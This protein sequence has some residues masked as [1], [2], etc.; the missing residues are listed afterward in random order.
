MNAEDSRIRQKD[1]MN[2]LCPNCENSL[3]VPQQNAGQLMKCPFCSKY[4]S[5]PALPEPVTPGAGSASPSRAPPGFPSPTPSPPEQPEAFALP[6]ELATPRVSSPRQAE[7]IGGH[8]SPVRQQPA[9]QAPPPPPPT[10]Y[11]HLFTIW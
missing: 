9:E 1:P 7:P 11:E 8:I 5:V 4:F 2:L 3:Y 10:G 6:L